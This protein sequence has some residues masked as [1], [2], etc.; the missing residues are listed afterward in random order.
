MNHFL[1]RRQHEHVPERELE[2]TGTRTG[3]ANRRSRKPN[4]EEGPYQLVWS[5]SIW[6]S[7]SAN[8]VEGT[9]YKTMHSLNMS[10]TGPSS[11]REGS[12][13]PPTNNMLEYDGNSL[14]VRSMLATVSYSSQ[15][16]ESQKAETNLRPNS[17]Y[18][19][20]RWNNEELLLWKVLNEHRKQTW[21]KNWILKLTWD[22]YPV[23]TAL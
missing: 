14:W 2:G 22:I 6:W 17:K 15:V 18:C 20:C 12:P 13:L 7:L 8:S 3:E 21:L 16:D 5:R 9:T 4:R 19:S 1:F 23:P 11:L 10:S